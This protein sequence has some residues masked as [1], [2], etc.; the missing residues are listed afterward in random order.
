MAKPTK[1]TAL[2]TTKTEEL[3]TTKTEELATT[4]NAIPEHLKQYANMGNAGF[5]KLREEDS[6]IPRLAIAQSN[7]P[8]IKDSVLR[9]DG[10]EVGQFFNS[11]TNEIYGNKVFV[12]PL[13]EFPHRIYFGPYSSSATNQ[14]CFAR[15]LN[16]EGQL[17]NGALHPEGCDSCDFAKW[18]DKPRTDGSKRPLC[19]FFYSYV[20]LVHNEDGSVEPVVF[21]VKSK[22]IKAAQKWHGMIRTRVNKKNLPPFTMKFSLKSV[23]K[24]E[25]FYFSPDNAGD[26]SPEL[27]GSVA[28][29]FDKLSKRDKI[30]YDTR[31]EDV[32]DDSGGVDD[33]D[34]P[35]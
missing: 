33:K 1:E 27:I 10:L 15:D 22:A 7:S 34:V 26:V 21:S 6:I 2:E 9:I 18:P 16:S 3:E 8:Q 24:G 28:D 31:G 20:L 17:I 12:T 19:T 4:N 32:E 13:T 23:S 35:F 25:N 30:K 5:E 11:I 14:L 29:W